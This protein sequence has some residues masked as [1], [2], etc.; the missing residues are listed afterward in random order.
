MLRWL[1]L[2]CHLCGKPVA[3]A[4]VAA[5]LPLPMIFCVECKERTDGNLNREV[6]DDAVAA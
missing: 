3:F 1:Q 2:D 4:G 6:R 5:P